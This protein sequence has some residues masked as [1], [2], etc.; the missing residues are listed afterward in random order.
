MIFLQVSHFKAAQK[1]ISCLSL[2]SCCCHIIFRGEK[3]T[4]RTVFSRVCA[5]LAIINIAA[6]MLIFFSLPKTDEA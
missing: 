6:E 5:G 2:T 3:T 1:K 4:A